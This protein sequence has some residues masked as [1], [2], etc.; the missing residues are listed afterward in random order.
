[1]KFQ[2]EN[3]KEIKNEI[4]FFDFLKESPENEN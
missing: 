1:M 3:Y 2:N 4:E